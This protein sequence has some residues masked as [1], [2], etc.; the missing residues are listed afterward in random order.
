MP[1]DHANKDNCIFFYTLAKPP[2]YFKRNYSM[3]CDQ[4]FSNL[5]FFIPYGN[6][7]TIHLKCSIF[8]V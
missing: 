3:S 2:F 6:A 1:I 7:T 5:H 4:I 8:P